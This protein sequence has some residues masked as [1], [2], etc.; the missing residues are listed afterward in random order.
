M[1]TEKT[2]FIYEIRKFEDD[3][4]RHITAKINITTNKVESATGIFYYLQREKDIT[5]VPIIFE[6]PDTCCTIE[7]CFEVFDECKKKAT[8][9]TF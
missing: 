3:N 5:P 6:L 8:P 9:I 7:E 2:T 1:S 4:G